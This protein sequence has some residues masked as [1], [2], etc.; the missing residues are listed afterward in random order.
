M[1]QQAASFPT[2]WTSAV[3]FVMLSF[4]VTTLNPKVL[5]ERKGARQ[6]LETDMLQRFKLGGRR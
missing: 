5:F 3:F 2:P 4:V 6:T 1:R